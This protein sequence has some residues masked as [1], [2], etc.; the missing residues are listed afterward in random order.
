MVT[1][2]SKGTNGIF[3]SLTMGIIKISAFHL[4]ETVSFQLDIYYCITLDRCT[5]SD[6]RHEQGQCNS[7]D[8]IALF[9][10]R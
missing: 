1:D 4:Y 3:N 5:V 6:V 8:E 7:P 10:L 2:S 9:S